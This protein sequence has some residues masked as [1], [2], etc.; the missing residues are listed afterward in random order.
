M[1]NALTHINFP[2]L[3]LTEIERYNESDRNAN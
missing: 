2:T 1:R 3:V